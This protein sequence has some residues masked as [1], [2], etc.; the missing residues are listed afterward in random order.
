MKSFSCM[1]AVQTPEAPRDT[2]HLRIPGSRLPLEVIGSATP[3]N[4]DFGANIPFTFVPAC[5][6]PCLRFAVTV[7]GHHA[8]L[9]TRLLAKLYRGGHPRPPNSMRFPRRNAPDS[10]HSS[11]DVRFPA[12]YV[13]FTFNI[14]RKWAR[15]WTSAFVKGCRTPAAEGC[16]RWHGQR[17]SE[18]PQ[19]KKPRGD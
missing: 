12:D 7:T 11:A 6:P 4:S 2:C 19:G 16:W 3:T 14:G 15:R 1:P 17:V 9:G 13:R 5:R 18:K 10:R 8:R